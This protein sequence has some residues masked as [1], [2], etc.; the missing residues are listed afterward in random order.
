MVEKRPTKVGR[1]ERLEG[2]K[3]LGA[4]GGEAVEGGGIIIGV[5]FDCHEVETET[6]AGDGHGTGSGEGVEN[7]EAG[8][9]VFLKLS[10]K[11]SDRFLRRVKTVRILRCE[12]PNF[13]V[14]VETCP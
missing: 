6:V 5:A 8:P 10:H 1:S 4:F 14:G 13:R 3:E 12:L 7:G 2:E 9:C 11:Q